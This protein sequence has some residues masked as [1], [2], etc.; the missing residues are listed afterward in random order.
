MAM[1]DVRTWDPRDPSFRA[2]PYP[3][4]RE[5]REHAPVLLHPE[6]GYVISRYVDVEAILRDERFSLS[7]PSPW[8]ELLAEQAVPELRML[9]ESTLLFI[10]PPAHSRVRSLVSKAFTPRRIAEL[11][12]HIEHTAD[13]LLDRLGA[14][15]EFDLLR[16]IA[17][18]LPILT[19]THLLGVP[20]ADWS[21]LHRWTNAITAFNELPVDFAALAGANAAA[22]EFNAYCRSII[23]ERR[24]A[25]G[26]DLVSALVAAEDDGQRLSSDEVIG[27]LILLL[28]AGYDTT[29]SLISSGIRELLRH[30]RQAG[31]LRQEPSL[32]AAAIEELLRYESPLHV[33]SG[34][35]RWIANPI[36]LHGVTLE[37]AVPVRLLLGSAN[38]D[39]EIFD[40]PDSLRLDREAK[41]HLAFGKGLHFCLGA[42]LGRLEGQVIIPRILRRF[43][44]LRVIRDDLEW[45]PSMVIR[46]LA[47]LPVAP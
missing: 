5:L 45:R 30:P 46:Q 21:Q 33:A 31:L 32:A 39:P 1:L 43:P 17:E 34:G 23:A 40:D 10:D 16:E 11:R 8:R 36:V 42:A 37:P 26:D 47:T 41:P 24:S 19:I 6:V 25:P 38:R 29:K 18:P 4:Y 27:M 44:H 3:W 7:T 13:A 2:D 14:A 20:D 15:D 12:P 9:G 35:G 22:S 28:M